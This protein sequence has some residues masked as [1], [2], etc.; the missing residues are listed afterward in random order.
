MPRT[1]LPPP[2]RPLFFRPLFFRPLVVVLLLLATAAP[3]WAAEEVFVLDNGMVLRGVEVRRTAEEVVIRLTDLGTDAR[4]TV[5]ASRIVRRYGF[6][7]GGR[8][9]PPMEALLHATDSTP[10]VVAAATR[11]AGQ[12]SCPIAPCEVMPL[13]LEDP[14]PRNESYFDRLGRLTLLALPADPLS[15]AALV[16]LGYLVLVLLVLIGGHLLEIPRLG[17]KKSMLLAAGF[18]AVLAALALGHASLLRADRALWVLPSLLLGTL[19]LGWALLRG[20]PRRAV[21]LVAFLGFSVS[22]VVFAS[23]AVLMIC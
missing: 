13:P 14:S 17:L 15:Q 1:L 2:L 18:G 22:V 23:G 9:P 10:P 11:P 20:P 21:L 3:A 12:P 5:A 6:E 8:P 4:V 7:E 16:F 19:G